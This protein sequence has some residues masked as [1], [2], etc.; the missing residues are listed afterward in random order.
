MSCDY[1]SVFLY[2]AATV[3][4]PASHRCCQTPSRPRL[5]HGLLAWQ[6]SRGRTIRYSRVTRI[7]CASRP[8]AYAF[9]AP[10]RAGLPNSQSL[11]QIQFRYGQP[12]VPRIRTSRRQKDA[13]GRDKSQRIP[14][15][16]EKVSHVDKLVHVSG[17]F[18]AA[19]VSPGHDYFASHDSSALSNFCGKDATSITEGHRNRQR[20]FCTTL[21]PLTAHLGKTNGVARQNPLA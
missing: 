9:V 19:P 6:P 21:L 13:V 20:R 16:A 7:A 18:P 14:G 2:G 8:S 11:L 10:Y 5:S 1:C 12:D 15:R 3:T 4:L 17:Y